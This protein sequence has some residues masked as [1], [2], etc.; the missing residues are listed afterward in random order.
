MFRRF[1]FSRIWSSAQDHA[2]LVLLLNL[3]GVFIPTWQNAS[4]GNDLYWQ[5][6]SFEKAFWRGRPWN[7]LH[8]SYGRADCI[9]NYM[10]VYMYICV[11][12]TIPV[13]HHQYYLIYV[14]II[15][16]IIILLSI[17]IHV[18]SNNTSIS[19]WIWCYVC[20]RHRMYAYIILYM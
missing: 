17:S 1:L 13:T 3:V 7:I 10:I 8:D 2:L 6:T 20:I 19:S 5:C 4:G 16:Y 14:Y 9:Y 11:F 18:F 15:V 12:K